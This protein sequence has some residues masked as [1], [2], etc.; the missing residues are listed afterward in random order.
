[1]ATSDS[2][3][4]LRSAGRRRFVNRRGVMHGRGWSRRRYGGRNDVIEFGEVF[5]QVRLP[6]V[7]DLRLI[8]RF[9]VAAENFLDDIHASGYLAEGGEP[10]GIETAVF[11][12]ADEQLSGAGVRPGGGER[13]EAGVI[14]LSDGIVLDCGLG[15]GGVDLGIRTKTE[16]DDEAGNDAKE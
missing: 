9:A 15:P 11:T 13:Q 1:M 5:V 8:R 6:H 4:L 7:G 12:E 3:A 16:L 2:V 10:L 14:A